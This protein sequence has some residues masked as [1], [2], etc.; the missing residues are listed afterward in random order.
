MTAIS[1]HPSASSP[2]IERRMKAQR[3]RDTKPEKALRSELWRRGLRYRVDF[4][5]VGGRRRVDIVFTRARVAVFV[6]GCFWHRCPVHA[7]VPKAN[8]EWWEAKLSMNVDRD[9]AT[10]E[11]LLQAGWTVIRIWEHERAS[12]AADRI[13]AMV[14]RP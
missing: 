10:D 5:V 13:E 4:K 9:R 6:D 14:R 12:A 1:S 8:R 11:A 2:D 7:T 3:R